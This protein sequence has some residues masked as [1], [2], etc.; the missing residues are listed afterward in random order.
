[1]REVS[2]CR[3]QP[4]VGH[5]GEGADSSLPVAGHNQSVDARR[6]AVDVRRSG[7]G[8]QPLEDIFDGGGFARVSAAFEESLPGA[9]GRSDVVRD[10]VIPDRDG[11][12]GLAKGHEGLEEAVA[13]IKREGRRCFGGGVSR[14]F[15]RLAIGL[16]G[17]GLG[18]RMIRVGGLDLLPEA[19]NLP[20]VGSFSGAGKLMVEV[21]FLRRDR[22]CG[23]HARRGMSTQ[24]AGE[25]DIEEESGCSGA[26]KH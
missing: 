11:G 12:G 10:H 1:M 8:E 14:A 24:A 2:A 25:P 15:H 17:E 7:G 18:R 19:V 26:G 20:R 4:L 13:Q 5:V 22:R 16:A 6:P 23:R 21:V 3:A 9:N